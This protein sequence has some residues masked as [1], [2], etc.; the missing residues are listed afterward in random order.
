MIKKRKDEWIRG[1]FRVLKVYPFVVG[2]LYYVRLDPGKAGNGEEKASTRFIHAMDLRWLDRHTR[3]ESFLHRDP[4]PFFPVESLFVEDGVLYQVFEN[5]EGTL[6][7]HHLYR[8]APLSLSGSVRILK[9]VAA[10]LAEMKMED[11]VTVIHPQNI[12]LTG[13]GARFLLGGPEGC[14]PER[15]VANSGA[16]NPGEMRGSDEAREVHALGTLAYFMLT[17][18]GPSSA[19]GGPLCRHRKNVPLEIEEWIERSLS[20]D[21]RERPGLAALIQSLDA[22]VP[23]TDEPEAAP[24]ENGPKGI[25][26]DPFASWLHGKPSL[27]A[28]P[29]TPGSWEGWTAGR[30]FP[31]NGEKGSSPAEGSDEKGHD[32]S[33]ELSPGLKVWS[34]V[35]GKGGDVSSDRPLAP[36]KNTEGEPRGFFPPR[37]TKR[38]LWTA[39][40]LLALGLGASGY[41]FTEGSLFADHAEDAARYYGESVR[42]M[43]SGERAQALAKAKQAVEADPSGKEYWLYLARL[44][45]E[46]A[47]YEQAKKVMLR[48]VK[49]VPEAEMYDA[50]AV[51]ALYSNDLDLAERS[52]RKAVSLDAKNAEYYFHQSKI[53]AARQDYGAAVQSVE[54][55][56][57]LS[58][59]EPVYHFSLAEYLLKEGNS[60]KA[61]EHAR[62]AV[63]SEPNEPEYRIRLGQAHLAE[64]ERHSKEKGQEKKAAKSVDAAVRTLRDAI[65]LNGDNAKAHYFLSIA[66]YYRGEYQKAGES[67]QRAMELKPKTAAYHYQFGVVLQRLG[68]KQEAA[69]HYR[70][71]LDLDPGNM[72]YQKAVE[73]IR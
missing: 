47:E 69:D 23:E 6:L 5:L 18:T 63:E 19:E 20:P 36:V 67:A 11:G 60:K 29:L 66:L 59:A 71:A 61:V 31:A 50:L 51:Y 33:R 34:K 16:L 17:G 45:G 62:K 3:P 44:Y 41:F 53:E 13:D 8:S 15:A 10:G 40:V 24:A 42:F 55:A 68:R 43:Q 14:L 27:P 35:P 28:H 21:P 2:T 48:G 52:V 37:R 72:R 58:P 49:S 32:K 38:F 46:K 9:A 4:S 30:P 39:G 26:N 54:S 12:F 64:R 56:I 57:R 1:V 22:P 70:K 65:E 7:A 73:Q 25:R